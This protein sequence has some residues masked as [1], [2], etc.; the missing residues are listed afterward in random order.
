M[1]LFKRM[2]RKGLKTRRGLTG[3]VDD[4]VV[5]VDHDVGHK[6]DEHDRRECEPDFAGAHSL[7]DKQQDEDRTA[8]AHD[9]TCK[10]EATSA[11]T[12]QIMLFTRYM[13][14]GCGS[15]SCPQLCLLYS[16]VMSLFSRFKMPA[17]L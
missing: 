5:E 16:W 9:R 13:P 2:V 10:H 17:M 8:D 7:E 3:V 6:P 12:L 1:L 15:P 14:S 11:V 4:D